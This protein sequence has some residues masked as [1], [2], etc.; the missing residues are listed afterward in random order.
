MLENVSKIKQFDENFTAGY[1]D[2]FFRKSVYRKAFILRLDLGFERLQRFCVFVTFR[3]ILRKRHQFCAVFHMGL[4][5]RR[6]VT[7]DWSC[8]WPE[9]LVGVSCG[10]LPVYRKAYDLQAKQILSPANVRSLSR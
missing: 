1:A 10:S 5:Q 3:N 6:T 9:R 8:G 2:Y 4:Y 7:I